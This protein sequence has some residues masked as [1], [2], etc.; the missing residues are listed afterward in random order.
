M[1]ALI[2]TRARCDVLDMTWVRFQLLLEAMRAVLRIEARAERSAEEE[3]RDA[4]EGT[5][6]TL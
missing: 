4:R 2:E 6:K 1:R 3:F 5:E